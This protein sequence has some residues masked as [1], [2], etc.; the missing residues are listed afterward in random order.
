MMPEG[1]R[2]CAAR[3]GTVFATESASN[4]GGPDRDFRS[5]ANFIYIRHPDRSIGLYIHLQ[6]GGVAVN[7]GDTVAR[8]QFIGLSGNTGWSSGP[9]LHFAVKTVLAGELE[10]SCPIRFASGGDVVVLPEPGRIYVA[11]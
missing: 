4:I 9:H 6:Q 11:E 5:D 8:G 1:T 3:E 10:K 7:V 2:V